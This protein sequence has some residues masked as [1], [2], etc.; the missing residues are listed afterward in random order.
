MQIIYCDPRD[1]PG[2]D[3]VTHMVSL[4]GKLLSVEPMVLHDAARVTTARKLSGLWPRR[5]GG[6][7][8]LLVCP[9]PSS[10][11]HL[12]AVEDWHRRFD[13]VL[14]WVIDS[15][16]IEWLPWLVRRGGPVDGFFVTNLEE[17]E[18]WQR[19]TRRPCHWLPWGTDALDL[20]S[21]GRLRPVDLFRVGR[22]PPA[23]ERDEETSE[24]CFR[25]GL[26][27]AG[28]PPIGSD[29][30]ENERILMKHFG[31]AKFTLCF[32]NLVNP[33]K[34]TH[35]TREYVTARWVD[36][37]ASGA[38]VAGVH[39]RTETVRELLWPE[40]LLELDPGDRG[41]GIATL[42][43]AARRWAPGA[44]ERNHLLALERL[45]WRWRLETLAAS[46]GGSFPVL[47]AELARL[48]GAIGDC[49]ARLVLSGSTC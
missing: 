39:P 20:G 47:D 30:T 11:W 1:R 14:A 4:A 19:K 34:A 49:R 29:P 18:I 40:G 25:Q 10:L 45:D 36:A 7:S 15:F 3:P 16:W 28:R 23:W 13:R 17:V 22:Q 12:L 44:A 35:P 32:S 27:F 9:N 37:L 38:T 8:C 6:E 31:A 5:R 24:A 43:E 46:L 21:S 26:T 2:W 33:T 48:R 41:A 42:A